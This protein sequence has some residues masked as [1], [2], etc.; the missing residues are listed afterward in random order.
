MAWAC[1]PSPLSGWGRCSALSCWLHGAAHCWRV[2]VFPPPAGAC[3]VSAHVCW[4]A[5]ARGQREAPLGAPAQ[6]WPDRWL[7]TVGRSSLAEQGCG[8]SLSRGLRGP[9]RLCLCR[10]AGF[11]RHVGVSWR[12]GQWPG[13][14]GRAVPGPCWRGCRVAHRMV[15]CSSLDLLAYTQLVNLAS[16][17][18]D[19][20][21]S[22]AGIPT[23]GRPAHKLKDPYKALTFDF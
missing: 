13:A 11:V 17:S 5:G 20:G 18:G 3:G 1:W 8:V 15:S 4:E 16:G 9:L 21:W 6:R 23:G 7:L 14:G 19:G 2:S 12:H 10:R 22:P